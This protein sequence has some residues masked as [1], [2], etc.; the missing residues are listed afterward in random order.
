[1]RRFDTAFGIEKHAANN[2][3]EN[4]TDSVEAL[5]K[6]D[7]RSR[8]FWSTKNGGVGIGYGLQKS[9]S[10]RNHA[11]P[12]KKGPE[13]GDVGGGNKPKATGCHEQ[14]A[15]KNAALVAHFA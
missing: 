2:R 14:Q 4:P 12:E 8:E 3:A 9:Q 11:Y 1:M 10:H 6:I 13:R 5:G 15:S 7:A